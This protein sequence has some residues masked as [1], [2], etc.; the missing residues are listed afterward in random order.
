VKKET[1]KE[2]DRWKVRDLQADGRCSKE[3]LDFL[4]TMDVCRW[5]PEVEDD[6]TMSVVLELKV[7]EWLEQ[8][9]VGAT[10][11][12]TGGEPLLFLS[13]SDF[14]VSIAWG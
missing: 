14:M 10:E 9:G 4:L 6:D 1:G 3:V 11:Q 12:D 5:V 7:W 13:T 2:K 8:Q